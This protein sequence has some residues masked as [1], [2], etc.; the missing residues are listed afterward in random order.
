[1]QSVAATNIPELAGDTHGGNISIEG[2]TPPPDQD[3][4]VD[5][6]NVNPA[7]FSAMRIP[8]LAGRAFEDTDDMAHPLVAIVNESLAR[9]YFGSAA[10]A[11][12]H[13]LMDGESDRP[14]Y[15]IEIVGVV[16]DFKESGIRDAVGPSLFAP[17][18]QAAASDL[19]RRL[20]F[21]LRSP[22]PAAATMASVRHAVQQVDA[23]LAIDNLRTMD[24]QI[25]ENLSNDRLTALLA[26]A[27]GVL[28]TVLA[29]VGL[30]GVL[31]YTTAQRT[32]EIGIRIALGS[33]RL[34]ISGLVL[35]DV[36]L[37]AG[38]GIAVA[39]PVAVGLSRVLKSQFYGVSPADPLTIAGAVVLIALVALAAALIPATR[40]ASINPTEALRTE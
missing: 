18:R 14:V 3:V 40:A 27:F 13:H 22:L 38:L 35:K 17:L 24:E 4:D 6:A 30:Y 21:Y 31:A 9:R 2:Y 37:L 36:L 19:S 12:H 32:R 26:I 16:P 34:A 25:D 29:G 23:A 15:N 5:K 28:A 7:Y 33:S 1:V 10:N 39:L 11:L 20:Y 8:L